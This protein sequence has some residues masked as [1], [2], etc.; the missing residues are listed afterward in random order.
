MVFGEDESIL[1]LEP[2]PPGGRGFEILNFRVRGL[3]LTSF[4]VLAK[5]DLDSQVAGNNRP[6]YPK[7]DHCWFK[8]AHNYEPLALQ[9][10]A[11]EASFKGLVA[12]ATSFP[13]AAHGSASRTLGRQAVLLHRI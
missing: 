13:S 5:A 7:V 1:V 8:V 11:Q 4:R 6:L 12:F 2:D 10:D 3:A 9:G